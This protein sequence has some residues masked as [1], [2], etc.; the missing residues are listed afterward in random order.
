MG[1]A[2]FENENDGDCERDA[3][4]SSENDPRV[5]ETVSERLP[6]TDSEFESKLL[7][8]SENDVVTLKLLRLGEN[9]FVTV[10]ETLDDS[11]GDIDIVSEFDL[12]TDVVRA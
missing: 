7:Q 10:R 9:N 11:M 2:D 12:D 3:D 1:V 5:S 8:L 6:L 4:A